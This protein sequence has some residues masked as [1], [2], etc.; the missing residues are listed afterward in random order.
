MD[1]DFRATREQQDREYAE[2]LRADQERDDREGAAPYSD[3][4]VRVPAAEPAS[5]PADSDGE[6]AEAR[7]PSAEELRALR[8]CYFEPRHA[9]VASV[10]CSAQTRAGRRCRRCVRARVTERALCPAH[11][12]GVARD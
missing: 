4:A 11:R 3:K 2:A 6:E 1:V 9:E 7:L 12:A 8:L 10:Q 5:S